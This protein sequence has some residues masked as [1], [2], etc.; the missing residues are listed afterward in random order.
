[1]ARIMTSLARGVRYKDGYQWIDKPQ[2]AQ[3][4]VHM[5]IFPTYTEH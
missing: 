1:V 3:V 2:N 4:F 5:T